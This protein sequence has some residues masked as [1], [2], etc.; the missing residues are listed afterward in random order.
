M[1]NINWNYRLGLRSGFSVKQRSFSCLWTF[2][3]CLI[4]SGLT[5]CWRSLLMEEGWSVIPQPGTW[6]TEKTLGKINP[7]TCTYSHMWK[8]EIVVIISIKRWIPKLFQ[9]YKQLEK[10]ISHMH[11]AVTCLENSNLTVDQYMRAINMILLGQWCWLISESFFPANK[12]NK[13]LCCQTL[14]HVLKSSSNT[15]WFGGFIAT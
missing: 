2:I 3:R 14:I 5:P 4:T 12:D 8:Q 7:Q 10:M 1:P 13:S 6:E 15:D 11:M 9:V